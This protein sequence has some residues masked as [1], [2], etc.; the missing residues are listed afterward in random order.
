M[1]RRQ[2]RS[3]RGLAL[4][5]HA[6]EA[7]RRSERKAK[8]NNYELILD[9]LVSRHAGISRA[10]I[11]TGIQRKH[12]K[13]PNSNLT[14]CLERLVKEPGKGELIARRN[15]PDVSVPRSKGLRLRGDAFCGK[16]VGRQNY[17][18]HH[19]EVGSDDIKGIV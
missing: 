15:D 5:Y 14:S 13:Y 11:L 8:Y 2:L 4:Y 16:E 6:F 9:E 10:K 17:M 1:D 12:P 7:A 19:D 3:P 18:L